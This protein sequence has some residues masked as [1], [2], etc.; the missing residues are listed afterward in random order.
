MG[1]S[2]WSYH[3][4]WSDDLHEALQRLRAE[5]FAEGAYNKWWQQFGDPNLE[6]STIDEALELA[7]TEGTHSILDISSIGA[8]FGCATPLT[9]ELLLEAFDTTTPTR[10]QAEARAPELMRHLPRW[11]A[12][13]LPTFE[14]D[15]PTGLLFVGVSGD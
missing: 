12:Y 8:G 4:P 7:D 14:G 6:A 13:V 1:A 2:G 5:V 15:Q 9:D 3:T 10:A 11:Q